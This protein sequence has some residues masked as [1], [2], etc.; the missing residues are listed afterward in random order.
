MNE[1]NDVTN[2]LFKNKITAHIDTKDSDFYNGLI[3]EIHTTFLV[4][5]D[6]VI[7]ETPIPYSS[8]KSIE[9]FRE[10]QWKSGNAQIAL[11]KR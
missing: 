10:R 9:R 7:G 11:Q 1:I 6:R 8:I 4:I 2:F 3:L 5:N